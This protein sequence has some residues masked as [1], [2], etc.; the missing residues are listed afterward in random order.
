MAEW[1]FLT[2]HGLVL[3]YIA[4][5]P[6]A[7]VRQIADAIQI[8]EWTVHKVLRELE[9][10][11]Y[12]QRYRNG[13]RNKYTVNFGMDL[14]HNTLRDAAVSDLLTALGKTDIKMQK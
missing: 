3:V 1:R 11:G 13:R 4:R 14:R 12:L 9:K 5:Y 7:T 6:E 8:T 10:T 2:S